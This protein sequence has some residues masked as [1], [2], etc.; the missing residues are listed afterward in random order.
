MRRLSNRPRSLALRASIL[1]MTL[2]VGAAAAHLVVSPDQARAC[3]VVRHYIPPTNYELVKDSQAIVLAKAVGATPG[4]NRGLEQ[5]RFLI[6]RTIK[7]PLKPRTHLQVMGFT[8]RYFGRSPKGDFS[9]ARPGAMRGSCTAYDYKVGA[10]YL[11]FMKGY[12]G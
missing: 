11:L 2:A 5:V 10:H 9:R 6:L 1:A 3:S 7:G 4:R 12:G 8:H